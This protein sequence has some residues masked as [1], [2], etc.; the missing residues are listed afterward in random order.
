VVSGPIEA[1]YRSLLMKRKVVRLLARKGVPLDDFVAA[2]EAFCAAAE[3]V[4][5]IGEPPPC[6]DEN[7]RKY[8]HCAV[9]AQV[10]YLVSHDRDLLDQGEIDGIPIVTPAEVVPRLP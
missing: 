5:P 1:E 8:L 10:D 2:V 6:R 7:D 9:V 4:T 3:R